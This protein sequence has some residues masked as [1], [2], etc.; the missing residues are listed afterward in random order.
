MSPVFEVVLLLG[1]P[2]CGKSEF[3]D[4]M[5]KQPPERLRQ[6]YGLGR[7]IILDD[8]PL[9]WEKFEE[10]DILERLGLPRLW[11][12]VAEPSY[13]TTHPLIW[14]F[15]T[16]KLNLAARKVLAPGAFR[17]GEETL[18][19]E[20][21]RGGPS[22]YRDALARFD[23]GILA[24][25]AILYIE[26]SHA[27]SCRRNRARYDEARKSSILAHSVPEEAM[28]GI[29]ATDDWPE[30]TAAG[31]GYLA[32]GG[33]RVPY[34]TMNNEPE[35]TDPV[36]LDGRYHRALATLMERWQAR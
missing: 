36:V 26:V 1:R 24:R 34:A 25:A 35:S 18:L 8:F 14:P 16:E 22:G 17:P 27:E 32:V 12:R 15:L 29:Y 10:D 2:A 28:Q 7:L 31:T 20:F 33:L 30:L 11:S 21:S 13:T 4:Y 6:R 3:L 19:I 5:Q 23:P 9:L